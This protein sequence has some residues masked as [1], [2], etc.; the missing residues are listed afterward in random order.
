MSHRLLPTSLSARLVATAVALVAL[1]AVLVSTATTLALMSTLD[2]RL[3][4]Q[5][6]EALGRATGPWRVGLPALPPQSRLDEPRD[7]EHEHGDGR[8][9]QAAGTVTA[10]W[11]A[12]GTRAEM[13]TTSGDR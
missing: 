5:V 3:D 10:V 8:F 2:H 12:N 1:V 7:D 11:D 13:P 6:D 9:G 4:M